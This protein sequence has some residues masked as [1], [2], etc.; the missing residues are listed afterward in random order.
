MEKIEAMMQINDFVIVHDLPRTDMAHL[1]IRCPYCGKSDRIRQLE[2]PEELTGDL[3]NADLEHYK[4]LRRNLVKEDVTL[5]ICKF[6]LNAL[7]LD[8]DKGL[9]EPLLD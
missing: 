6:C 1:G 5:G 2:T 3:L 7:R 8:L 9:A 4:M